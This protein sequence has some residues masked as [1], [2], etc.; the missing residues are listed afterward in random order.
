MTIRLARRATLLAALALPSIAR[1]Q[2]RRPLRIVVPF[3][4]GGSVDSLGRVLA[5]RLAP[6]LEQ[7]VVVDNRSGGGGLIGADAVAKGPADGT[8]CGVIGAATLCA[9]P[10]L[11]QTMPFDVARDL[12]PVTQ[13]SDSAVLLAVNAAIAQQRG[14]TDLAA[15][16]AWARANPGAFRISHAGVAT[17]SHLMVAALT[18]TARV[19]MTQVPY[20]G[21]A[22]MTSDLLS[23]TIEGSA[24]LPSALVPHIQAGRVRA[25]GTSSGRRLEFLPDIP[26]FAETPGLEGI[27]IRSWNAIMVPAATPEAEVARLHAAFRQVAG[28]AS[29]KEAMRPLGYDAVT[30]ESP[31]ATAAMI[32]A[33]TPRWRRLVELSGARVE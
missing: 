3:P 7:S 21:G 18:T 30:S 2:S 28:T 17:V 10:F 6:V 33:E 1:A 32:A 26:A 31:A 24:D 29:F 8:I 4:P 15:L 5:D 16:L 22:Q 9:A 23:G 14:W 20:R 12:R 19:E 27:D 25:L 11:Q 13:I